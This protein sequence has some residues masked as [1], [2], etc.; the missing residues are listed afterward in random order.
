MPWVAKFYTR[1]IARQWRRRGLLC[2]RGGCVFAPCHVRTS[3]RVCKSLGADSYRREI[4]SARG[5]GA[6][7]PTERLRMG[8]RSPHCLLLPVK[9][10]K[11]PQ[12]PKNKPVSENGE[13]TERPK[14]RAPNPFKSSPGDKRAS[15]GYKKI[16]LVPKAFLTTLSIQQRLSRSTKPLLQRTRTLLRTRTLQNHRFQLQSWK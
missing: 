8:Q 16:L 10:S 14:S 13:Y 6:P 4:L 9:T 2:I 11:P 1:T 15:A 7:L 12:P 5:N 3:D